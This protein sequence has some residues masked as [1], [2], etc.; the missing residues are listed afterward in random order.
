MVKVI[1]PKRSEIWLVEFDPQVASEIKKTRPAIVLSISD[2][3]SIPT[4]YVVPIRHFEE[5][6]RNIY[7]FYEL[8]PDK[9]NNLEK[10]SFV[11]CN[12]AKSVS[13]QRFKH[14]IGIISKSEINEI[15]NTIG[16]IIGYQE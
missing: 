7:Y 8:T 14:K 10:N 15:V 12:Q 2:V 4:R 16:L 9:K 1:N 6:F 5:K 13:I 3:E 11:D